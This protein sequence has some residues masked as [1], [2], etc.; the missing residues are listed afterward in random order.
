MLTQNWHNRLVA[1]CPHCDSSSLSRFGFDRGIQ[2]YQCKRCKKTFKATVNTPVYGLHKKDKIKKYLNALQK[3]LSVRK[4]ADYVGIS[5]NTSFNWRHKLLAS[6][7][8]EFIVKKTKQILVTA[9]IKLEYSSKGRKKSPKKCQQ[10]T[11]T[12]IV[13]AGGQLML[14]KLHNS[15]PSKHISNILSMN[16]G[17]CGLAPV[18]SRILSAAVSKLSEQFIL[19]PQKHCIQ[20]ASEIKKNI[21]DVMQWM[22]RFRGVASKYLQ[23]YW[24]WYTL[25]HNSKDIKGSEN[26]F[27]EFCCVKRS[28][29]EFWQLKDR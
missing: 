17:R 18:P 3:G 1:V 20:F 9:I 15:K 27:F 22:G 23:Q 8:A 26:L 28:I 19:C 4:A 16:R 29:P 6:L 7:P 14:Q 2:R 11:R 10:P 25:L 12:L 21:T 5:K 24:Q 13:E